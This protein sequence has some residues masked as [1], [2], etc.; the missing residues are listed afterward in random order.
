MQLV[1]KKLSASFTNVMREPA[2]WGS[3]NY[4]GDAAVRA[5]SPLFVMRQSR[6]SM[7]S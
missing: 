4:E 2:G 3:V 6:S 5:A 7:R 1:V